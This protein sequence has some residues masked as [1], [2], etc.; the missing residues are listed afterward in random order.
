MLWVWG[1]KRSFFRRR[2]LERCTLCTFISLNWRRHEEPKFAS[3]EARIRRL[4]AVG[5]PVPP[6]NHYSRAPDLVVEVR[7]PERTQAFDFL[8]STEY[9]LAVR[10]TNNS[11]AWLTVND[12]VGRPPWEDENFFWLMDPRRDAPEKKSYSMPSGRK[13]PYASVLNHCIGKMELA[14]G[15]SR[16][17]ILLAWSLDT[18]I[19]ADCLHDETFPLYIALFDQFGRSHLSVIEV[20][21]N[22]SATMRRPDRTKAYGGGLYAGGEL[23]IRR[24]PIV[25]GAPT[26]KP[27]SD[28][29]HLVREENTAGNGN[30]PLRPT[31]DVAPVQESQGEVPDVPG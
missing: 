31:Q 13:I 17:G 3:G 26:E 22:R 24:A 23:E 6:E 14:P 8:H 1:F 5:C 27:A 19:P 7:K 2:S 28:D 4:P 29:H 25:G 10:F 15:E 16:K 18:R 21:V 30:P 9:I 11:Y 20:R 12:I